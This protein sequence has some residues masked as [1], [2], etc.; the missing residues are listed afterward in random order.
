MDTRLTDN[1]KQA[2]VLI[3]GL[4]GT[5]LDMFRLGRSLHRQNWNVRYWT[6]RSWRNTIDCAAAQLQAEL[7]RLES[8]ADIG[9]YHLVG[10]SL[11]AIIVRAALVGLPAQKLSRIVMLAPPNHGSFVASRAAPW[12]RWAVPFLDELS[13]RE[14]SA[15]R[16]IADSRGAA[17]FE[18]GIVR[19]RRDRV[20]RRDATSLSFARFEFEVDTHHALLPW[21]PVT[22]EVV[23]NFLLTGSVPCGSALS[24][25]VADE[26]P[27]S[28][29]PPVS[30]Q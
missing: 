14:N 3:H 28:A 9:Q 7:A 2:V 22:R 19:A 23:H 25:D 26:N 30:R 4:M 17:K 12:F 13:D 24:P 29:D 18:V 1:P 5:R 15:V 11:G 27:T 21:H 16:R 6:Y 8:T 10:H 20:V